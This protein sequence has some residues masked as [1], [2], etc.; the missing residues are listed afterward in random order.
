MFS[1]ISDKFVFNLPHLKTEVVNQKKTKYRTI[2][3]KK[4]AN[5]LHRQLFAAMHLIADKTVCRQSIQAEVLIT[6]TPLAL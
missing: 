4:I 1:S 6:Q 2:G 3:G 5:N